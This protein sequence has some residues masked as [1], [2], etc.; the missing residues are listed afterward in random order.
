MRLIKNLALLL[1][2]VA[3]TAVADE[4]GNADQA[5]SV[6]EPPGEWQTITID[7]RE[8]TWSDVTISPDGRQLVFHMLG[9]LYR[10]GIDGGQAEAL[11]NDIAWNFQPRYSPDGRHIAFISDRD[12]AENIW[13]MDADGGNLHQVSKERDHLLHNPAWSPDGDYIAA[14]KGYVS[15]R[16]IPAGAI[17]M[18]H[19]AGGGGVELVE[20]L[21]GAQSQKNIAEPFFSPDGQHL[22][23][24]QDITPGR[25]WEYNRDAIKGIFAVRRLDL[26]SG[27]TETVV[28]GPG[29]AVRPVLSPDGRQLAFVRRNPQ[30][31]SSRLMVR[32]LNSG[33]ERTLFDRL[34]RDKQETSGDMGNFPAF[35]WH[36]D[37]QS[38]VIWSAGKFHRIGTDGSHRQ[39]EVHVRADKQIHPALRRTVEVSPDSFPIRMARWTQVSPDGRHAIFQALGYLWLHDLERGSHRRLTSQ[40]E[41]WE[42]YPSFSPDSSQVVYVT[43]HDEQLGSVRVHPVGR[44]R[45]RTLTTEPGHYVEPAFSPDGNRVVFR[46]T[47]GGFLTSPTWSERPGLY[48]VAASGGDPVRVLDRGANPQFAADGRHILFSQRGEGNV[49]LLKS[50]NLDGF[51]EREHLRGDWITEYKVSPDGRWV[52]FAEHYNAYLAPF[53]AAGQPVNLS[54]GTGAF[55]VRQVSARGGENLH[56]SA[57]S[58]TLAWAHGATLYQ[59]PLRDAFAFLEGAPEELPEPETE[60]R[61]LSFEV[62]SDRHDGR[63]ALVGARVVTMRNAREAQEVIDDGVILVEGHRIRAVGSRDEIDIPSGFQVFDLDGKTVLPGLV[64]AHAHGPMSNQQLTPQQNWAQIANVAFGVTTTHDPSNDNNGIFSMAELQRAGDVI[65]PRLYSTGRILYGAIAPGATA[66]IN[67]YED[68]EF[69]VRRHKE[70]GAISVKSYNY[71]RRDQRQQVLKAGRELDIMVVPEGGMRLEQN[72]N[73]IVDGHTGLEHA[74]SVHTIYDDLRQFWSQTEVVYSPTFGVAYG[75]LMGE[76]YW[77][78]RTEVWKN[79]RLLAFVPRFLLYPRSIRRPTAPDEHYNHIA[80]AQGAKQLNELGVPVVIGAHGQLAGLA[81]HWEIW[82]MAQGGFTPWEALRGATIDGARYFGMDADIGSI[83]VG[84]LADL[85][86]VDGDVLSDIRLSENV[87]YTMLNGRL[88]ESSTMNQLAPDQVERAPLFFQRE[89]GDAWVPETMARIHLMGVLHGWQCRH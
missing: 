29:G 52:A 26:A 80:V 21:H 53:F 9:D 33:I 40:N 85:F 30:T 74:L 11:T 84:K 37:G 1:S 81:A 54:A 50:V 28:G 83:E 73:Q 36:P 15:Q 47:T 4:N 42:F 27:E 39:I 44:G 61:N 17:W 72:L 32:E 71:N 55:P 41:H 88:Y 31:L 25:V 89:G 2:A 76:E 57:D 34:D 20:R 13:I 18:Y 5:W 48:R 16:S 22:Y 82:M 35:A 24:S 3:M 59:R 77:Y 51:E 63:I 87:A 66:R 7:T 14:R 79:E 62:E 69:H 75:G 23:Y 12:G 10:V 68:A 58:A 67:S 38:L 86:V 65:A 70:L 43:W 64:D 8:V 45:G 19:R 78:D 49:L 60:G 6:T 46:K 56:F